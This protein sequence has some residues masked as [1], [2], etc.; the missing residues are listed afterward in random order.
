MHCGTCLRVDI[1][2]R[3]QQALLVRSPLAVGRSCGLSLTQSTMRSH[4]SWG[5]CAGI[6]GL[7]SFPRVRGVS[8]T[9]NCTISTYIWGKLDIVQTKLPLFEIVLPTVFTAVHG[10]EGSHSGWLAGQVAMT[11]PMGTRRAQP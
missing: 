3:S 9:A 1:T 2:L 4:T 8:H 5:H 11:G 6:R 10:R 7:G